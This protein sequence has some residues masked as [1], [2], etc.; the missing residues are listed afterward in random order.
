MR[1][2]VAAIL[3]ADA[4][5]SA[6]VSHSSA[7]DLAAPPDV[8][9]CAAVRRATSAPAFEWGW[10]FVPLAARWQKCSWRQKIGV[11]IRPANKDPSIGGAV[12]EDSAPFTWSHKCEHSKT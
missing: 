10:I 7:L 12:T 4:A 3:A 2:L 8:L 1:S 11:G 5:L 6:A 9:V